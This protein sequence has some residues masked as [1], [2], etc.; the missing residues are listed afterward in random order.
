MFPKDR[1][2]L[3]QP[4]YSECRV[5]LVETNQF[6]SHIGSSL[7]D[8]TVYTTQPTYSERR[9]NLEKPIISMVI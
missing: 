3:T 9:V 5:N 6:N 4:I 2:Y 1:V 8:D 7:L